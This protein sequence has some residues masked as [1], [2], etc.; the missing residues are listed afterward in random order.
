MVHAPPLLGMGM[1][2][3]DCPTPPVELP[4]EV[5]LLPELPKATPPSRRE[6]DG[7]PLLAARELEVPPVAPLAVPLLEVVAALEVEGVIPPEEPP[8]A[9]PP[10]WQVPLRHARPSEQSASASQRAAGRQ[11]HANP[12]AITATHSRTRAC[13]ITVGRYHTRA[14]GGVVFSGCWRGFARRGC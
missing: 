9:A 7:P 5:L 11:A 10:A 1:A 4:R 13:G 2:E 6:V 12:L 14:N 8:A 3:E